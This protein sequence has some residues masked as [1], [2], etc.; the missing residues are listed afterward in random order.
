METIS[1]PDLQHWQSVKHSQSISHHSLVVNAFIFGFINL[2]ALL[3]IG[4]IAAI[5]TFIP[6]DFGKQVVSAHYDI[7]WI[8]SALVL[9]GFISSFMAMAMVFH[10]S[11]KRYNYHRTMLTE[12]LPISES[13]KTELDKL[14][15]GTGIRIFGWVLVVTMVATAVVAV[16]LTII[17]FIGLRQ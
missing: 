12:T 2:F 3:H 17:V 5:I 6:T 14:Y 13:R 8:I 1:R 15:S 11:L 9:T 10:H 4:G 16:T 7:A